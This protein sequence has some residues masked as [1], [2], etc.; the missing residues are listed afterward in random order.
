MTAAGIVCRQ[1]LRRNE[2]VRSP[3]MTR[4]VDIILANPPRQ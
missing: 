4:G 3:N 1:Y 2:D